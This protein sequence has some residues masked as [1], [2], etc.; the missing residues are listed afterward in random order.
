MNRVHIK[1]Y[2]IGRWT[3]TRELI[4]P[5]ARSDCDYC[6]LKEGKFVYWI[7]PDSIMNRDNRIS[8]EFCSKE[9]MSNYHDFWE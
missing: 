2:P 1:R 4:D 9:C 6:G 7:E 5:I 3:L 8:G